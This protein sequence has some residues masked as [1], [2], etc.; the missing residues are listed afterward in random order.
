MRFELID[1]NNA[2]KVQSY[3]I[4]AIE[5]QRAHIYF[6]LHCRFVLSAHH[7]LTGDGRTINMGYTLYM[8][9]IPDET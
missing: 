3:C 4:I 1:N 9:T 2:I 5:E 6:G 7:C 8:A